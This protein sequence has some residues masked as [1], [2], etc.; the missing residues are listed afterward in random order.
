MPGP[1]QYVFIH[2]GASAA[3]HDEAACKATVR[4]YQNYHMDGHGWS[5]IGY[6]FIVGEDGNVYMGR[7]WTEIGA[8]TLNFNSVGIGIC[9]IGDFTSRVPN[10]AALN[11]VKHLISC[12]L[13]NGHIR[14]SYTLKG[15]RDVGQTECPGTKLYELIHS[16]PHYASGTAHYSG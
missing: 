9:I 4:S 15:H 7:G 11:A 2:H 3:C 1:A 10:D 14:A 13:S 5:D 16:W 12:G 8:H 6:S